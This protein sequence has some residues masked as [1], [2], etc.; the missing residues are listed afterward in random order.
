MT[1][2]RRQLLGSAA[3]ALAPMALPAFAQAWPSRR[4][5][6]ELAQRFEIIEGLVCLGPRQHLTGDTLEITRESA[7]Q[8]H[9]MPYRLPARDSGLARWL[10]PE[11]L[12]QSWDP[13]IA[14]QARLIVSSGGGGRDR[15]PAR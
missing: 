14:A 10:Q 9:A 11:P 4:F 15:S 7:L 2:T 5:S 8:A 3:A 6:G 1:F 13:R 12:I